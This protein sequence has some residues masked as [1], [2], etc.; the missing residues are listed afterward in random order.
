MSFFQYQSMVAM[1]QSSSTA[2]PE[3]VSKTLWSGINAV[4]NN[5]LESMQHYEKKELK[6][7]KDKDLANRM[8]V[9][10]ARLQSLYN[11][12]E[13]NDFDKIY[14]FID[15]TILFLTLEDDITKYKLLEDTVKLKIYP[16]ACIDCKTA[17][18]I[19]KIKEVIVLR[20]IVRKILFFRSC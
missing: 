20:I 15:S 9:I 12:D 7:I 2:N 19:G 14:S 5:I 11:S 8:Q 17:Q 1:S 16:N 3:N 6:N 18:D 4:K 13:L 10:K